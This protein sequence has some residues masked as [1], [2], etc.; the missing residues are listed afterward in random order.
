MTIDLNLAIP[1]WLLY[2]GGALV[3]YF[4]GRYILRLLAALF[5]YFVYFRG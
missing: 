1:A 4:V 2:G 3:V 5:V